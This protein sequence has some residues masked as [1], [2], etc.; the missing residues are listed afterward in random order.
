MLIYRPSNGFNRLMSASILEPHL[1]FWYSGSIARCNS[2]P[3][4]TDR[5]LSEVT[6][7]RCV[8]T[9][10]IGAVLFHFSFSLLWDKC[11]VVSTAFGSSIYLFGTRC[12]SSA[13]CY[14]QPSLAIGSSAMPPG[15]GH[16]RGHRQ[17]CMRSNLRARSET[18][19]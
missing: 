4:R 14:H 9:K 6:N 10:S 13:V 3:V 18:K 12:I 16:R 5:S 11:N 15:F 8:G 19:I 2:S 17:T 1:P 7:Q